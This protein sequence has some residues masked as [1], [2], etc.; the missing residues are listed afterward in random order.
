MLDLLPLMWADVFRKCQRIQLRNSLSESKDNPQIFKIIKH[1]VG[2][3]LTRSTY[4]ECHK[5]ALKNQIFI[6]HNNSS[7]FR[8]LKI[9]VFLQLLRVCEWGGLTKSLSK[10]SLKSSSKQTDYEKFS[11]LWT[12]FD[13]AVEMFCMV[14]FS[15]FLLGQKFVTVKFEFS[16]RSEIRCSRIQ[17]WILRRAPTYS[18]AKRHQHTSLS[19]YFVWIK[20]LYFV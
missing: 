13:I 2:D 6:F 20:W 11:S 4:T 14:K 8:N 18:H 16:I 17:I 1:N 3:T 15:N 7:H 10:I 19:H 9:D 12:K 5:K